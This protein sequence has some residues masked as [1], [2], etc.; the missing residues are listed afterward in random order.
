MIFYC[1]ANLED[2]VRRQ[3]VQ[4]FAD[5]GLVFEWRGSTYL[6]EKFG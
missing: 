1:N 6:V 3:L 2:D 5:R 4:H